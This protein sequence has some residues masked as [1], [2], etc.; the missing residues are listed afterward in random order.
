VRRQIQAYID[1]GVSHWI[2]AVGAPF[3]LDM[4][5]LFAR[6]VMPAFR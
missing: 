2:M 5:A 1:V 4:L 6:E 3:D